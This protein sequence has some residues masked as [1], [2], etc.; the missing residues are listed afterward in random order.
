MYRVCSLLLG[1]NFGVR[2]TADKNFYLRL[3]VEKMHAFAVFTGQF[4]RS[5]DCSGTNF[6]TMVNCTNLKTEI[7]IEI[8]ETQVTGI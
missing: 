4:L 1:P 7:K 3:S 8:I 6:T 2:L 5:Y